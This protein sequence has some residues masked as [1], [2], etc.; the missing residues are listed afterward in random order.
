MKISWKR[1]F[2]LKRVFRASQNNLINIP[3]NS[4]VFG[5]FV[6]YLID[7]WEFKNKLIPISNTWS[8]KTKNMYQNKVINLP[9][10]SPK[11]N[12]VLFCLSLCSTNFNVW[13]IIFQGK[14]RFRGQSLRKEGLAKRLDTAS[15][16]RETFYD[17]KFTTNVRRP[18][19]CQKKT[20]I[21]DCWFFEE[22]EMN[23]DDHTNA[24]CH[25]V[26]FSASLILF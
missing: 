5:Y 13:S 18:Q 23:A 21:F 25:L 9:Q 12:A 16:S 14:V 2:T 7:Y 19:W 1:C 8:L 10:R 20:K 17:L 22:P 3:H 6:S 11:V 24:V 4:N 26:L 15:N